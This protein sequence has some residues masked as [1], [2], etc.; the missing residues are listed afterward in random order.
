MNF[1]VDHQVDRSEVYVHISKSTQL[2]DT[3]R[4][5]VMIVVLV[6]FAIVALPKGRLSE[7]NGALCTTQRTI[8]RWLYRRRHTRSHSEHGR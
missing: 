6:G 4:I 2:T 7:R 3:N 8:P 5:N 1:L